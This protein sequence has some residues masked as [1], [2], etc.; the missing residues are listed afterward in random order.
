MLNVRSGQDISQHKTSPRSLQQPT[1]QDSLE[2]IK[3]NAARLN[4]VSEFNLKSKPIERTLAETYLQRERNIK[5]ACVS[6]VRYVPKGTTFMYQGERR[7]L[8]H[9]CLAAFGRNQEGRLSSVQLTKLDDQG[10]RA[11]TQMGEK[12]NKIHYGIAKGSFVLLQKDKTT[13]RVFM[14]EGIET[15]LSLKEAGIEG[16]IVASMGIYNMENYQGSE[17]EIIICSDND[18]HKPH[19]QTYKTIEKTRNYF[20]AQG[21]SVSIIKPTHPGDDFNDVLKKQGPIGVQEYV[22]PYLNIDGQND[23]DSHPSKET[24]LAQKATLDPKFSLREE[25]L[26]RVPSSSLPPLSSSMDKPKPNPI[27]TVSQYL[28]SLLRKIKNF[29][30][31][32]L[33]D[34]AKQELKTYMQILQKNEITLQALKSYNPDLAQETHLFMQRQMNNK[35]KGMER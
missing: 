13:N 14:A 9:H 4:A 15:A 32:S 3:E 6:D 34:E 11:L 28:E 30:G 12:L 16:R 27:E 1:S 5:G 19:S 20:Q 8:H 23:H 33:A 25:A 18:E 26:N 29:E 21:K 7:T 22:K 2:Q 35:N 17:K 31:C 10:K 24:G